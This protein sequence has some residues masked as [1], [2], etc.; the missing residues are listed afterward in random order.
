MHAAPVKLFEH[1]ILGIGGRRQ[2][3]EDGGKEGRFS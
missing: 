3:G 2:Q 1:V